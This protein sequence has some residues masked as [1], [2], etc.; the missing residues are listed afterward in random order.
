[1]WEIHDKKNEGKMMMMMMIMMM[2]GKTKTKIE[3]AHLPDGLGDALEI[4]RPDARPREHGREYEVI[5]RTHDRDVV[6]VGVHVLQE[7]CRSPS[8]AQD[9]DGLLLLLLPRR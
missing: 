8:R 4:H 5:P 1:M 6:L 3:C 7:G 2:G 9:D